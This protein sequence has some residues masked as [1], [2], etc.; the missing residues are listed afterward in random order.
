LAQQSEKGGISAEA[1]WLVPRARQLFEW[2]VEAG[3]DHE[4]GG[5]IYGIGICGWWRLSGI[6]CDERYHRCP[7][8]E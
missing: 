2:A 5:L 8:A 4:H 7:S 3:W 1:A 6:V